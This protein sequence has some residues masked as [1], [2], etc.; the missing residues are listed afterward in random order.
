MNYNSNAARYPLAAARSP[1]QTSGCH[2]GH[3]GKA[4]AFVMNAVGDVPT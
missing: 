3:K 2:Y 1:L 4:V